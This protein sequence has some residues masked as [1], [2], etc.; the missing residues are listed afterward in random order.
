MAANYQS[1]DWFYHSSHTCHPFGDG[2]YVMKSNNFHKRFDESESDLEDWIKIERFGQFAYGGDRF[3]N[4]MHRMSYDTITSFVSMYYGNPVLTI[5]LFGIPAGFLSIIIYTTCF[6]DILDAK[7]EDIDENEEDD[8]NY[9]EK[10][11]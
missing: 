4:R 11:D 5:L 6:S 1:I 7:D 9:H 10:E 3:W 8:A 2:I